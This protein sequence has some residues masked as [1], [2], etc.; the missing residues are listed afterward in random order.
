M[1]KCRFVAHCGASR[2]V[3]PTSAS[4][5]TD[6]LGGTIRLTDATRATVWQAVYQPFGELMSIAGTVEQNLRFPG[7][8][9]LL[10][11][12]L[13]YNWYR[14]YDATTG[15]Y[16]Q[17]DPLRFVDGPSV[18][19]YARASLLIRVDREGLSSLCTVL[20]LVDRTRSERCRRYALS[21]ET[22]K[23]NFCFDEFGD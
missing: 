21:R 19:G 2:G 5:H 7:Q 11:T 6:H 23:K 12:G 16:T 17:P 4:L 22:E 18:Y 15:R 13:A 9:F 8:Y 1:E 20:R 14:H 3:S 10:E